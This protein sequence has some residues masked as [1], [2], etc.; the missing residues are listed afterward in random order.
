MPS[1]ARFAVSPS[2]RPPRRWFAWAVGTNTAPTFKKYLAS[3]GHRGRDDARGQPGHRPTG[4]TRTSP[5]DACAPCRDGRRASPPRCAKLF[6]KLPGDRRISRR[7]GAKRI[8]HHDKE[9]RHV[10]PWFASGPLIRQSDGRGPRRASMARR[11]QDPFRNPG[12]RIC[13]NRPG[14]PASRGAC[15]WGD[16]KPGRRG[17]RGACSRCRARPTSVARTNFERTPSE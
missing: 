5:R 4:L 17:H 3:S 11:G 14:E 15:T 16:G 13:P 6:D 7:R 8:V 9:R 12:R 1:T 2:T 10:G